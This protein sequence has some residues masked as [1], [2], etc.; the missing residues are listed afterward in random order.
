VN[1]CCMAV[2]CGVPS[3]RF[4]ITSSRQAHVRVSCMHNSRIKAVGRLHVRRWDRVAWTT[5]WYPRFQLSGSGRGK[6][7]V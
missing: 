4:V 6:F 3:T 5:E 1:M 2:C 7:T